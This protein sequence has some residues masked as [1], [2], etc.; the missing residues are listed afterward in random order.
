M[1]IA[2]FSD[3]HGNLSALKAVLAGIDRQTADLVVFAGDLCLFG[4][5]P[6][7]CLRLVRERRMPSVIGNTDGWLAGQGEPPERH[8]EPIAWTNEQ[9]TTDEQGWL[10]RLP[11]GL[12]VTP[13]GDTADDLLIVHANP[14]NVSDILFPSEAEQ[15]TRWG[16]VRQSDVDLGLLLAGVDAAAVAYG[17]LH[18]PG[19]REW[20]GL[21]L[22]NV[23]SVSMPGDEDGRAKFAVLEWR[24]DRWDVAHHRVNYDAADESAAFR[25]GRPP[26]WEQA[27]AALDAHG[28][29]YPQRI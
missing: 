2:I 17:H 4:P 22:I 23:S 8:R 7:E 13:T 5:R 18:I 21:T 3:V 26:G 15:V 1:R 19:V 11:F 29:Y 12:R 6:A 28:Y 10:G 27:V 25:A 24:A 14:R 16:Q 9:L 20:A